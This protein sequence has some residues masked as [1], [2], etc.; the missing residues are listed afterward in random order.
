MVVV[1]V[2]DFPASTDADF[3]VAADDVNVVF[4]ENNDVSKEE[5]DAEGVTSSFL[6]S[7][8]S[9]GGGVMTS[10]S[11]LSSI[12]GRVMTSSSLSSTGG[13]VDKASK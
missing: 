11:L 4:D 12:V 2:N 5:G 8:S 7:S 6:M 3:A 9:G 13:G 10:S 1:E